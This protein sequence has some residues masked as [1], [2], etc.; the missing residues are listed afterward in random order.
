MSMPLKAIKNITW[1]YFFTWFAAACM[2]R[3][4]MDNMQFL[5]FGVALIAL[6]YATILFIKDNTEWRRSHEKGN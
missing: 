4:M 1:L 6:Q 2:A 5:V 3:L